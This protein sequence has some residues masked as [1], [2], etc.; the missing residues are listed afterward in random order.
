LICIH[1]DNIPDKSG[2]IAEINAELVA[3]RGKWIKLLKSK[4]PVKK[5]E[6]ELI[7]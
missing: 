6:S 4:I 3:A 2:L 5:G 1:L 7:K